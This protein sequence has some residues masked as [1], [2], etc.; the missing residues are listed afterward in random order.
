MDRVEHE[1][2]GDTSSEEPPEVLPVGHVGRAL[3]PAV[4]EGTHGPAHAEGG[5]V[6]E[7]DPPPEPRAPREAGGRVVRG[8]RVAVVATADVDVRLEGEVSTEGELGRDTAGTTGREGAVTTK[9]DERLRVRPED[10]P[11]RHVRLDRG[12]AVLEGAEARLGITEARVRP[13]GVPRGKLLERREERLRDE[14]AALVGGQ[15][16]EL[17]RGERPADRLAPLGVRFGVRGQL[18]LD[19]RRSGPVRGA[20]GAHPGLEVRDAL[21]DGERALDDPRRERRWRDAPPGEGRAAV[22]DAARARH[23]RDDSAGRALATAHGELARVR[24]ALLAPR[25]LPPAADAADG[26][27]AALVGEADRRADQGPLAVVRRRRGR[28]AAGI[29]LRLQVSTLRAA[30]EASPIERGRGVDRVRPAGL[31]RGRGVD[32][33]FGRPGGPLAGAHRRP[34]RKPAGSVLGGDGVD[35]RGRRLRDG[36]LRLRAA[37]HRRHHRRDRRRHAH[38]VLLHGRSFFLLVWESWTL[39]GDATT[40]RL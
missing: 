4:H 24:D 36:G 9:D 39:S 15:G 30:R 31:A 5:A 6:G 16:P 40:A 8:R 22:E 1:V 14:R 35:L 26:R 33:G 3:Q 25:V 21:L 7:A 12:D 20:D 19:E 34:V 18:A 10:R 38:A 23:E 32:R 17:V 28:V 29:E 13:R 27:R 11:A 37:R 2:Q